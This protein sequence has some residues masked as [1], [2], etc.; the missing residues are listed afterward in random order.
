MNK[1]AGREGEARLARKARAK[2]AARSK[3]ASQ[4]KVTLE[5]TGSFVVKASSK[6]ATEAFYLNLESSCTLRETAD[7]QFSLV[8]A[9]GDPIII[10]GGAVERI[11]TAGL[12]LLVALALE[13]RHAGRRLEW[14][15]A[16]A[17]LRKCAQRLA[18]FE[19]L[20]LEPE[21]GAAP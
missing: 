9:K 3:L 4:V 19:V 10:D 21:S 2:S 18:L 13:Q 14:K 20:G 12:Q 6:P 17:E 16:S 7:L 1:P 11:D 15:A 8:A 5:A